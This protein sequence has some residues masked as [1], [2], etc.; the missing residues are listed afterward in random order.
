MSAKQTATYGV[1]GKDQGGKAVGGRKRKQTD[2]FLACYIFFF[3]FEEHLFFLNSVVSQNGS[4]RVIFTQLN[5]FS[6]V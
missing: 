6:F 1:E 3:F 4:N 5:H 2:R